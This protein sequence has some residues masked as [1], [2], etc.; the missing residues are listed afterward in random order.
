MLCFIPL[1]LL[2]TPFQTQD[3]SSVSSESASYDGKD[4]IL[5]GTVV[6]DHI[7]GKIQAKKA[8]LKKPEKESDYPF[9]QIR[10]DQEVMIL[11]KHGQLTADQADF[12]LQKSQAIL[13]A[14]QKENAVYQDMTYNRKL[15]QMV[16]FTIAGRTLE[17]QL[18]AKEQKGE[19]SIDCL[20][21]KK[22]VIISYANT[23]FLTAEKAIYNQ[24]DSQN[25]WK[26]TISAYAQEENNCVLTHEQDVVYAKNIDIDLI[27]SCLHLL[28]ANGTVQ[29]FLLPKAKRSPMCFSTA[30]LSWN[31][32]EKEL[33][34][35]GETRI[36]EQ[37]LGTIK[38]QDELLIKSRV[39]NEKLVFQALDA[40]GHTIMTYE[41]LKG[42]SHRIESHGRLCVDQNK[43]Q[44]WVE[45]PKDEKGT[46]QNQLSYETKDFCVFSNS[47]QLDYVNVEQRIKPVSIVL[48]NDICM[49]SK[50]PNKPKQLAVA[51][52]MSY[53]MDTN[54]IILSAY[55]GKKVLFWD[56][57]QELKINA[58]EVHITIDPLTQERVIE[59]IGNVHFTFN[60]EEQILLNQHFSQFLPYE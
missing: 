46:T 11:L 56:K 28:N 13:S 47:A 48:R 18:L 36:E 20:Q 33:L 10:L 16:P 30:S 9:D 38:T 52:R 34:F 27:H 8:L 58:P 21:A 44:A 14:K 6:I 25:R 7:L 40:K 37:D 1:L 12:N 29:Q 23:F 57:A 43:L 41:D 54:S 4:L 17:M 19:Y 42:F 49:F 51:D 39:I 15:A 22:N 50:D 53:S 55:P 59:G 26:G 45:S 31:D 60:A 24:L 32:I 35:A 3:A 5:S 2:T